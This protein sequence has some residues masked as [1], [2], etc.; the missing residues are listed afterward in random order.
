VCVSHTAFLNV[1]HI[2]HLGVLDSDLG[3]YMLTYVKVYIFSGLGYRLCSKISVRFQVAG[4]GVGLH[5]LVR[6][7]PTPFETV[8]NNWSVATIITPQILLS[9]DRPCGSATLVGC[10]IACM[11][12]YACLFKAS[13]LSY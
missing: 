10:F 13:E 8:D 11:F 12:V 6:C 9:T 2:S 3:V 1:V 4:N 5:G 7:L